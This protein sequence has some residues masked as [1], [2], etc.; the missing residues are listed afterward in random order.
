MIAL[1]AKAEMPTVDGVDAE[2]VDV[3]LGAMMGVNRVITVASS[4]IDEPL[5]EASQT[6][7][8]EAID[9]A[10]ADKVP[11]PRESTRLSAMAYPAVAII[12]ST[13]A[14][15]KRYRGNGR[16]EHTR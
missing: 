6:E 16:M 1:S 12:A 11:L 15:A 4:M 13:L 10:L 14:A 2:S 3:V 9:E 7:L 5:Q 8:L